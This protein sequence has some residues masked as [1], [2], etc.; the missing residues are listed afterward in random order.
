MARQGSQVPRSERKRSV[1][2]RDAAGRPTDNPA[3]AVEGEVI[4]YGAHRQPVRR[5]RFFLSRSELPWLPV[6]EPAFLLWVLALLFI[7][8]VAIGLFLLM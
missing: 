5:A 1:S 6:S 2:Y 3:E 4:E 7:V 8:W